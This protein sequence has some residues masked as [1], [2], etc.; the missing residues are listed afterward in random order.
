[1]HDK[2]IIIFV[3]VLLLVVDCSFLVSVIIITILFTVLLLVV[4]L[5]TCWGGWQWLADPRTAVEPLMQSLFL[6]YFFT[7]AA[8]CLGERSCRDGNKT[9]LV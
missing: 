2:I 6:H 7:A 3:S 4:S 5:C 9:F 1:M 8:I